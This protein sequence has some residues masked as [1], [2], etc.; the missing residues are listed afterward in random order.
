LKRKAKM[1]PFIFITII[2]VYALLIFAFIIRNYPLGLL[3]SM[4]LIVVGVFILANGMESIEN[5][6]TV[7]L[8]VICVAIGFYILIGGSLQQIQKHLG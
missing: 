2:I 7:S 8:G 6:L 4:A 3:S 5:I 1:I